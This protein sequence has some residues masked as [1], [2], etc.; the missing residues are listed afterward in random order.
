MGITAEPRVML[1]TPDE[2]LVCETPPGKGELVRGEIHMSSL[3]GA[4]HGQAT[5]NLVTLLRSFVESRALGK[6]FSDGVGF[7]LVAL[8][9]TVRGPDA[10]FVAAHRLPPEGLGP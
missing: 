8:P 2:F 7:E 6:V 1:M 5:L 9:R 3:A 10:S 4:P